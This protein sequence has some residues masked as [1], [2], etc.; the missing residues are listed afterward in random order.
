MAPLR[1]LF[2]PGGGYQWQVG[3]YGKL[4]EIDQTSIH[5]IKGTIS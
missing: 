5:E 4:W 2:A 3:N 1:Q